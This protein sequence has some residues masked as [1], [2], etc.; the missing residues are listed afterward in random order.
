MKFLASDRKREPGSSLTSLGPNSKKPKVVAPTSLLV[1]ARP[2]VTSNLSSGVSGN[3][4]SLSSSNV[5]TSGAAAA[6]ALV[7][8]SG[9]Q[10]ETWEANALE[11]DPPNL[12]PH[13][14]EAI[15]AHDSDRVVRIYF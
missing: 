2:P 8:G 13:I 3:S 4:S 5:L 1:G 7:A 14:L 6:G 15:H 12:V 9:P 11:I 10:I